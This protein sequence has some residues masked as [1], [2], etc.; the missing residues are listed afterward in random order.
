M[1][2]GDPSESPPG[3]PA[4]SMLHPYIEPGKDL[5]YGETSGHTN[6]NKERYVDTWTGEHPQYP[7]S[8]GKAKGVT[9]KEAPV[10]HDVAY[11]G[12]KPTSQTSDQEDYLPSGSY[13]GV[14]PSSSF[15]PEE[16]RNNYEYAGCILASDGYGRLLT[17]TTTN[18]TTNT[19]GIEPSYTTKDEYSTR[20][21]ENRESYYTEE[22]GHLQ[23][24]YGY[25]G[26]NAT[27]VNRNLSSHDS[28]TG[29]SSLHSLSPHHAYIDESLVDVYKRDKSM[30]APSL[31]TGEI[32][33]TP[34]YVSRNQVSPKGDS[35]ALLTYGGSPFTKHTDSEYDSASQGD[36]SFA[37]FERRDVENEIS[38]PIA[39]IGR[40]MKSVLP[41]SAKIAKH[42]KDIVR[43]CVTEFI[44]FIS[45]EASDICTNERRKTLSADD[46]MSAMNSLGFEHYN[47][48]LRSYHCRLR[49]REQSRVMDQYIPDEE[50]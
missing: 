37:A 8:Y 39:N 16:G 32:V 33:D 49:E 12:F 24:E 10:T 11:V 50:E 17:T 41:G 31:H 36:V 42:A 3:R 45:S 27:T 34:S 40:V 30:A 48:A 6:S 22:Q 9:F 44:M 47:E 18:T 20:E 43:D 7:E 38:L 15:Y 4:D 1:F 26:G 13:P 46:I 23:Y 19:S 25:G 21:S 14:T 5:D 2:E 29:Q 35:H 28:Y